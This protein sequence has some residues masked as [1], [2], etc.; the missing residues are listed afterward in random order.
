MKTAFSPVIEL[1]FFNYNSLHIEKN[2]DTLG[3]K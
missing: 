2:I 3:G 1:S